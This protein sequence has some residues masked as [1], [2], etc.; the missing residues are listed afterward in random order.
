MLWAV[1]QGRTSSTCFSKVTRVEILRFADVSD[2]FA[3]AEAEGDLN[4]AGFRA[5][6]L[7]YWAKAGATVTDDT[8]IVTVYFDLLPEVTRS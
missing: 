7:E 4:A 3:L 8:M 6:H 5:S 2:E 1:T